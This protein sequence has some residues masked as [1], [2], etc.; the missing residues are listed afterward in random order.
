MA[1]NCIPR[2]AREIIDGR[3]KVLDFKDV[4]EKQYFMTPG[5]MRCQKTIGE[6]VIYDEDF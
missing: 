3:Q 5:G 6:E 1:F 4:E 2:Q